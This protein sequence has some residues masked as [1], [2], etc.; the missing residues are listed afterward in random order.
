MIRQAASALTIASLVFVL[1][2]HTAAK[3]DTVC[4]PGYHHNGETKEVT[5][6]Q[7]IIHPICDPDQDPLTS[8]DR[9]FCTAKLRISA[10]ERAIQQM[11]FTNDARRFEMFADIS[12]T[13]KEE[14]QKNVID[15]LID[16]G[17]EATMKA[18][19]S[20]KS[21]NPISVN[22]A[23]KKLHANAPKLLQF[24][25][26]IAGL[27]KIAATSGKPGMVAA[28]KEFVKDVQNV[29]EVVDA[30]VDM[31]ADQ[32]NAKLRLTLGLLK[33]AQNDP[34]LGVLVTSAEFGESLA[35]LGYLSASVDDLTNV[36]DSKLLRLNSYIARLKQ[37]VDKLRA[38]K[39]IW[40]DKSGKS[41][42]PVCVN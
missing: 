34:E 39:R 13:E 30:G 3:A 33:I 40:A 19:D 37:D 9:E 28:Y 14:L 16:Q 12:Q 23:I 26:L 31:T 5:A 7:I 21:L 41:G 32:K 6:T 27:R 4:G 2:L 35:Y 15:G 10:D 1:S 20:V 29:K 8:S 17:F 11:S 25:F 42:E 18:A 24:D 38:E 22:S 36:T